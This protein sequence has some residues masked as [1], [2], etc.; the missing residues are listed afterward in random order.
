M[1]DGQRL[2]IGY[3]GK[4]VPNILPGVTPTA[5]GDWTFR[6]PPGVVW[7][8]IGG[9]AKLVTSAVVANRQVKIGLDDGQN[10]LFLVPAAN[11]QAGGTT[12]TYELLPGLGITTLA[13]GRQAMPLPAVLL[14]DSNVRLFS[15]TDLIDVGDKWTAIVFYVEE[16]RAYQA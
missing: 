15:Q 4:G 11:V 7:R 5:G 8:L 1:E 13:G 9:S 10:E 3:R 12:V 14:V 16:Y 2:P 6:P